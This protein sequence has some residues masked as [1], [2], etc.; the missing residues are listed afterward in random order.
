M[1]QEIQLLTALT[2][3]AEQVVLQPPLQNHLLLWPNSIPGM[4]HPRHLQPIQPHLCWSQFLVNSAFHDCS[5]SIPSHRVTDS[6]SGKGRNSN[7]SCFWGL[8]KPGTE[9]TAL[10]LQALPQA[11][12][13][14]CWRR[15]LLKYKFF[16]NNLIHIWRDC[17]VPSVSLIPDHSKSWKSH[18]KPC[19]KKREKA[20]RVVLHLG[21]APHPPGLKLQLNESSRET[22]PQLQRGSAEITEGSREEN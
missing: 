9:I 20:K 1:I 12:K 17:W 18:G 3:R 7:A 15:A 5:M 21:L 10:Q 19:I 16:S 6:A 13:T 8:D 22:E 14:Q 11:G 2:P 4:P